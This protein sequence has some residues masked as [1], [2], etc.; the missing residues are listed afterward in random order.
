MKK[1]VFFAFIFLLFFIILPKQGVSQN[2]DAGEEYQVIPDDAIRL[3]ILANSDNEADQ[4][5]K[6]LVRDQ[7]NE[8]ITEWVADITDINEARKLIET[9]IPEIEMI[10]AATLQEENKDNDFE[11]EY[12]KNVTFPT[13]L[14]GS[15]LYPAGEYEAVLITIGEG[16]GAN[17]WCV[18]FPPLC[19]LDF[20]NGTTVAAAETDEQVEV[21][22][23]EAEEAE[24]KFFL[25]EWFDWL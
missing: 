1:L 11:V 5:L 2:L 4:Q 21:E 15:Y 7:V 6:R 3:R 18:L 24:V 9:R 14:Y 20:S 12:G 10:V 22:E 23:E 8:E 25:F 13:K 16:K 17:W 19:F